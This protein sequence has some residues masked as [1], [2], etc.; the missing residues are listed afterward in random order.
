MLSQDEV[1]IQP[2]GWFLEAARRVIQVIKQRTYPIYGILGQGKNENDPTGFYIARIAVALN[3][4]PIGIAHIYNRQPYANPEHIQQEVTCAV[5]KG[6]LTRVGDGVYSAS[7][8]SQEK[9][10]RIS[11]SVVRVYAGVRPI[12]DDKLQDLNGL[13]GELVDAISDADILRY[14]PSFELDLR[15]GLIAGSVFQRI[16]SKLSQI[17]AYRDDAYLNAWMAQDVNGPVWEAFTCIY[18]GKANNAE[19][20]TNQLGEIRHY[21][22]Q[23]YQ[24]A[25]DVMVEKGWICQVGMTFEPTDAGIG[26]MVRE[27]IEDHTIG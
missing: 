9:Y 19:E 10:N 22:Q 12:S 16:C 20:I 27:L 11:R 3:P 6:W 26:A 21:D 18:Q 8:K 25:L 7:Q 15:F 17:L 14:K 24:T 4:Q 5:R 13:L 23:T 1:N 2:H